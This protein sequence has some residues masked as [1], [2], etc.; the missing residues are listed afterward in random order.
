[1]HGQITTIVLAFQ[2]VFSMADGQQKEKATLIVGLNTQYGYIIPHSE[3]LKEISS[4]APWGLT[5]DVSKLLYSDKSWSNCHCYSKLGLSFAYYN[6][7]NPAELGNSYNLIVFAE[8][9]LGYKKN[10]H[11]TLRAG[12][13]ATYLN[14]VYDEVTN[15]SNLFLDG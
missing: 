7:S 13:G 10:V 14:Q 15:P 2:F 9:F 4:S 3:E 5:A 11:T 6:Y 12:M 1:M 8:P